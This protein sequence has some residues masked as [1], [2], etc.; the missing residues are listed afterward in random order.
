M[1]EWLL[2]ASLLPGAGGAARNQP[3]W[4]SRPNMQDTCVKAPRQGPERKPLLKGWSGKASPRRWH[5]VRTWRTSLE[6]GASPG[7]RTDTWL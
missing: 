4:S 3:H 5:I 2:G 1:A 6:R 7:P